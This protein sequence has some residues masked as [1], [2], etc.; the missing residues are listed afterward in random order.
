MAQQHAEG[1]GPHRGHHVARAQAGAQPYRHL[2]PQHVGRLGPQ[3]R[4]H[5]GKTFDVQHQQHHGRGRAFAQ[6]EQLGHVFQQLRLVRQAGGQ[7]GGVGVAGLA[8]VAL[9][10]HGLAHRARQ[11][12]LFGRQQRFH[13]Q[14]EQRGLGVGIG[15]GPQ[16]QHGGVEGQLGQVGAD[17]QLLQRCGVTRPQ[18]HG[19]VALG[20]RPGFG[21]RH[22]EAG[23]LQRAGH[24]RGRGAQQ[25]G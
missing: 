24:A 3:A 16:H 14:R 20:G 18:Q 10:Q 11:R 25:Q 13:A 15:C 17:G 22:L 5:G 1:I 23:G 6:G 19:V 7:V 21:L 12:G 9:A 8:L 4:G 2:A